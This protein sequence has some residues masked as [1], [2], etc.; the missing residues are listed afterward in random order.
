MRTNIDVFIT[1]GKLPSVTLRC[2]TAS[3]SLSP[4]W[5]SNHIWFMEILSFSTL[6]IYDIHFI[7]T[8][9]FVFLPNL[10]LFISSISK[11]TKCLIFLLLT[12]TIKCLIYVFQ[13]TNLIVYCF[14]NYFIKQNNINK[15]KYFDYFINFINYLLFYV[16]QVFIF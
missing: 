6:F 4:F 10:D 3:F 13:F 2:Y 9:F 1:F 11:I 15:I 5:D 14:I 12:I 7:F 8:I 16:I